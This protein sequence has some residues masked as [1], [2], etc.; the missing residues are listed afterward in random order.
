[1]QTGARA[2]DLRA[3]HR[4]GPV[5]RLRTLAAVVW[6]IVWRAARRDGAA[7]DTPD[8]PR[9]HAG[10]RDWARS[11][12]RADARVQRRRR[13]RAT[14]PPGLRD[15]AGDAAIAQLDDDGPLPGG[16]GVHENAR[17][18]PATFPVVAEQLQK[19]GYRTTAFV[20]SFAL[21]RR[22]GLARGF[23]LYDDEL[24][25]HRDTPE[26]SPA[27]PERSARDTADAAIGELARPTDK[28]RFMWVHFYDPHHPY[29][30]PEPY[31][32]RYA[33]H[34]YLGEVAVDGRAD[35]ARWCR[36][37]SSK[38]SGPAAVVIV[39]DHGEGLGEHGENQHGTLIFQATMHVPLVIM[40]PGV[41]PGV[42]DTPVSTRRVFHTILDWAGLGSAGSLRGSEAEIVLGEAMKRFSSTAGSRR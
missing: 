34:P 23:D 39:A 1:M 18:L 27:G 41:A 37:S 9:H 29:A 4:P 17:F 13:P 5:G 22:F 30:P 14:V 11:G 42:S 16:H 10:G 8:Y 6:C 33:E 38:A 12:R 32:T 28:P 2:G 20:S 40:G 19:A 7:G 26:S 31:R 15:G 35:R 24:A 21:A 25:A 3:R 36:P